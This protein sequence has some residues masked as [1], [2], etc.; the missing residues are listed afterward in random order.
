MYRPNN[1]TLEV[2]I[3][4][5]KFNN[6]LA[7]YMNCPNESEDGAGSVARDIWVGNY[8]KDSKSTLDEDL[9]VIG[10]AHT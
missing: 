9:I 3:E 1:V 10:L 5:Y 8:L 2:I 6:S 4:G 7:G